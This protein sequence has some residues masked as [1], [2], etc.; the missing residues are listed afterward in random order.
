MCEIKLMAILIAVL[1]AE[2]VVSLGDILR[3]DL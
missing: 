1:T 2:S 3:L